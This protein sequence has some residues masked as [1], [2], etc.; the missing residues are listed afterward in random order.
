M[1]IFFLVSG[2]SFLGK[3][4]KLSIDRKFLLVYT[5]PC[6]NVNDIHYQLI[7]VNGKNFD[8]EGAA[9]MK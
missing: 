1:L 4:D 5:N 2:N 6:K 3:N 8:M 9:E 7:P